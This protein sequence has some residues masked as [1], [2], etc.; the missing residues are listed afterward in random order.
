[1]RKPEEIRA[2][3]DKLVKELEDVKNYE[4]K[5]SAAVHILTNL[6]W[7]HSPLK[8][9]QKPEPKR[10]WKEFDKDSMTHVKAG[11]WVLIDALVPTLGG[12]IKCG[13]FVRSVTGNRVVASPIIGKSYRGAHVCD[14]RIV[15][16]TGSCK[17]TTMKDAAELPLKR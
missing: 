8:G 7:T 16:V 4:N 12:Q 11:D 10:D 3:I 17:V 14:M 9:W 5:R 15:L 6:G 13:C 2:D 1:M